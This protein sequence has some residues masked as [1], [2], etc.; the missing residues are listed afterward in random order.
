EDPL[1]SFWGNWPMATV[2]LTLT[3]AGSAGLIL[4]GL[5]GTKTAP[6]RFLRSAPL[7]MIGK[8]S[9]ALYAL[10]WPVM[11]LA[12]S[13]LGHLHVNGRSFTILFVLIAP[14][15]TFGLA[16]LSWHLIEKRFLGLKDHF[17]FRNF[18]PWT[19][20]LTFRFD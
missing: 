20:S 6:G 1:E 12:N 13:L 4:Y 19:S 17:Q 18:A 3:G 10:H 16:W 14:T 5:Q 9:Y 15:A 8:F 2:G 7:R 11:L